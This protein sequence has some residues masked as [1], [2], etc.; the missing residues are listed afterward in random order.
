M[1]T[2]DVNYDWFCL[3]ERERERESERESGVGVV[4]VCVT[5][6]VDDNVHLLAAL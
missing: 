1:T 5:M 3:L 4:M 2:S 6:N